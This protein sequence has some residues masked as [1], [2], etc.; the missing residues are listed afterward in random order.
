MFSVIS[1]LASLTC[2]KS[3]VPQQSS[4]C[5]TRSYVG[6][7]TVDSPVTVE[8]V[9]RSDGLGFAAS[10]S[11]KTLDTNVPSDPRSTRSSVVASLP[12]PVMFI[13]AICSATFLSPHAVL[14]TVRLDG[15]ALESP[16]G[17]CPVAGAGVGTW[18]DVESL[19]C[20]SGW[21]FSPQLSHRRFFQHAEEKCPYRKQFLQRR[22]FKTN[23]LLSSIVFFP[24][25]GQDFRLWA[26]WHSMHD[27]GFS[28]PFSTV[29]AIVVTHADDGACRAFAALAGADA[30]KSQHRR[31]GRSA[32]SRAA[33]QIRR[34]AS[35]PVAVRQPSASARGP[36]TQPGRGREVLWR[37]HQVDAQ[38]GF[39]ESVHRLQRL[40]NAPCLVCELLQSLM[41]VFVDWGA[42]RKWI[43]TGVGDHVWM[44]ITSSKHIK[45]LV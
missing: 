38:V 28:P 23:R 11:A 39:T 22:L 5:R 19:W 44:S 32:L 27:G 34:C 10:L 42:L 12:P 15:A 8:S 35:G 1:T 2:T 14:K 40:V 6:R 43:D 13:G 36:A 30:G 21:C 37:F 18:A 41:I 9:I 24:N 45:S 25:A 4:G 17:A 31:S 7:F 29:V 20:S 3:G 16:P 26:L 33:Q